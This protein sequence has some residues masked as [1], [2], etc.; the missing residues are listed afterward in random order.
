MELLLGFLIVSTGLGILLSASAGKIWQEKGGSFW[1]GTAL[2]A[3]LGL[4]GFL[5]VVYRSPSP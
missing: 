4:P 2:S 3:L 5:W 1:V